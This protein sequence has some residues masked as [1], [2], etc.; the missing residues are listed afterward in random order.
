MTLLKFGVI[1]FC[2]LFM[3]LFGLIALILSSLVNL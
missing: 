2:Y 3:L 1:S